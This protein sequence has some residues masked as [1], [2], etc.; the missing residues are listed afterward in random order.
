MSA[1]TCA[2]SGGASLCVAARL[3]ARGQ[4]DH[5]F[6]LEIMQRDMDRLAAGPASTRRV[7]SRAITKAHH[8][9]RTA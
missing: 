8:E 7:H 4:P 3:L 5:T 2:R 9:R 6:R 1:T